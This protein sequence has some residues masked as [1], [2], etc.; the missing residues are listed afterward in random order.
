MDQDTQ[1]AWSDCQAC[2]G[3]GEAPVYFPGD[4]FPVAVACRC[5]DG[6]G[7]GRWL[8]GAEEVDGALS[9][10]AL[11]ADDDGDTRRHDAPYDFTGGRAAA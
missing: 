8:D 5:C 1:G 9:L 4:Y 10:S 7:L 2:G 11:L 6:T 3:T